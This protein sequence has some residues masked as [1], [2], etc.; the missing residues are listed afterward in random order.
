MAIFHRI[1]IGC[2][3]FAAGAAA[4]AELSIGRGQ[5]QAVFNEQ[6]GR[7]TLVTG[8]SRTAFATV[9]AFADTGATVRTAGANDTRLGAGEALEAVYPDG[10]RDQVLI[11]KN[12]PFIFF[13]AILKNG[14]AQA[15]TNRVAYPALTVDLGIPAASL[16]SLGTGGLL[17]PDKNPGSY[18]WTAVADPATR[19]GVV[20]GWV[21][22]RADT[23]PQA[24]AVLRGMAGLNPVMAQR[25]HGG[26]AELWIAA[27]LLLCWLAPNTQQFL[28]RFRIAND[29]PSLS[30]PGGWLKKLLWKPSLVYALAFGLL[31][32]AEVDKIAASG[33]GPI[34]LYFQ[35]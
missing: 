31:L 20:A 5:V 2:L 27:G 22:F 12:Q 19:R 23:M 30:E 17:K 21:I 24:W 13:R 14:A 35:F 15:V 9:E 7:L 6:N 3:L 11:F 8:A 28:R 33:R 1:G 10:R 16:N 26:N 29:V 18:M 32:V 4:A 34:F 25:V